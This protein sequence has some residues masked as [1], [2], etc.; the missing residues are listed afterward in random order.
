MNDWPDF[1]SFGDFYNQEDY[2]KYRSDVSRF[3]NDNLRSHD[4]DVVIVVERK[5]KRLFNDLADCEHLCVR[6]IRTDSDFQKS[7]VV[8]KKVMIFDDSMKTADSVSAAIEYMGE[9]KPTSITV[10]TILCNTESIS[11]LT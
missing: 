6:T 2:A 7:E 10:M 9:D 11:N 1:S 8:G 5:G 4:P 3:I